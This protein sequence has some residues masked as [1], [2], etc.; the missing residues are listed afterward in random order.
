MKRPLLS[1]VGLLALATSAAAA[2]FFPLRALI[3][4]IRVARENPAGARRVWGVAAGLAN[5]ADMVSTHQTVCAPPVTLNVCVPSIYAHEANPIFA[6]NGLL[7]AR[8]FDATKLGLAFG[9]VAAEELPHVFRMKSAARIDAALLG[10]N[11]GS[12]GLFGGV[13]ISNGLTYYRSHAVRGVR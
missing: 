6:P 8:R 7:L 5:L 3:H 1:I 11:I 4:P 12:T 9:F 10:V 13:A 2:N